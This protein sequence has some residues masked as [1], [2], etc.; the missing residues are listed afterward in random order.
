MGLGRSTRFAPL[1]P[2]AR[3][4]VVMRTSPAGLPVLAPSA[5]LLARFQAAKR[6]LARMAPA[7]AAHVE[8]WRRTRFR[9]R[10]LAEIR[11]SAPARAALRQV[12]AEARSRDLYLVCMCPYRTPER[13]CHTY[14]L[15]DLA[16]ELDPTLP[17]R[18][19]PALAARR[20]AGTRARATRAARPPG[21]R[22]T[23]TTRGASRR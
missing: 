12:L 1:P 10:Y 17:L 23:G 18:P 6:A 21:R 11:R 4:I 20:A 7:G 2:G 19:E 3:R 13:A 8:A 9:A 14:V 22:R 15:L 5:P 16:R